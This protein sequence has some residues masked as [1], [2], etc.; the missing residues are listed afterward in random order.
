LSTLL[1]LA[2]GAR[3]SANSSGCE[4]SSE[5]RAGDPSV[6]Y[7]RSTSAAIG[8]GLVYIASRAE[9]GSIVALIPDGPEFRE[10]GL[11]W[12]TPSDPFYSYRRM[13]R[14]PRD[15]TFLGNEADQTIVVLREAQEFLVAGAS[16]TYR[17]INYG[18]FTL[19]IDG[20]A[21]DDDIEGGNGSDHLFDYGGGRNRL[22]GYGGRD[23]LEGKGT[24]FIGGEGDDCIT[25]DAGSYF[26]DISGGEGDDVL[27]STGTYGATA[28][29][30]GADTCSSANVDECETL[31]PA[32]CLGWI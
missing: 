10:L 5:L 6:G 14:L 2:F 27:E 31:A 3:A 32:L 7:L 17:P 18:G 13:R 8:E 16:R 28:G 26:A 23:W 21:G 9:D 24:V 30:P 22:N 19:S 15:T 20:C 12:P 4:L 11:Y 1:V 25:G 29:G